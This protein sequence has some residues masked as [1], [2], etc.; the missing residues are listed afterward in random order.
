MKEAV[1]LRTLA[2]DEAPELFDLI[3][4]NRPSLKKFWWESSTHTV[5]DSRDFIDA[6]GVSERSNQAISRGVHA[7][8]ALIGIGSVH[9]IDQDI[10]RAALGY[11]LDKR[12]CGKG[13]ATKV[14]TE[15]VNVAFDELALR[16]LVIDVVCA[17]NI[18]SRRV[19]EKTGFELSGIDNTIPWH[20]PTGADTVRVAH[21]RLSRN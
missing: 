6:A 9:H 17:D 12:E 11:W 19:A 14:A 1:C 5:E 16:E 8:D 13:L 21:Y 20:E 18:G 4:R 7:Y 10:G 3:D 2:P 15:L